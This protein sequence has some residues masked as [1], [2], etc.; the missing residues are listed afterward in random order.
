MGTW[1]HGDTGDTLLPFLDPHPHAH[2]AS[3]ALRSQCPLRESADASWA[4]TRRPSVAYDSG[5]RLPPR[6]SITSPPSLSS[7]SSAHPQT[8]SSHSPPAPLDLFGEARS[9]SLTS[10][11]PSAPVSFS[12]LNTYTHGAG[13]LTASSR[14][15][16]KT[17]QQ[18]HHANFVIC[19]AV[20][21][22]TLDPSSTCPRELLPSTSIP[23]YPY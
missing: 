20:S 1:G 12:V 11:F 3:P 19:C 4:R 6:I 2:D 23:H 15:L 17:Q 5:R 9:T 22:D 7:L 13:L 21:V 14:S 8:S 16:L 10:S 18:Q